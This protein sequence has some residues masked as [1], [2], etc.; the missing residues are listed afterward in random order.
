MRRCEA[1][2]GGPGCN[3][4][5][6]ARREYT[7]FTCSAMVAVVALVVLLACGVYAPN[8]TGVPGYIG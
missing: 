3:A 6:I 8:S 2:L 1:V 5:H 4:L 7:L